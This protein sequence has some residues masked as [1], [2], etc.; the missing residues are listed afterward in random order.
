MARLPMGKIVG[1]YE[2]GCLLSGTIPNSAADIAA[3]TGLPELSVVKLLRQ[4]VRDGMYLFNPK[5]RTAT[6]VNDRKVRKRLKLYWQ[7]SR[8]MAEDHVYVCRRTCLTCRQKFWS[9]GP[10][11]H[12]CASCNCAN[13][14]K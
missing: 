7:R 5:E 3:D 4:G 8:I 2:V 1:L 9:R 10:S 12:I 14:R 13:M 6:L 11:N